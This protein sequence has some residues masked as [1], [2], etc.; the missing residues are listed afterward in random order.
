MNIFRLHIIITLLAVNFINNSLGFLEPKQKRCEIERVK[1]MLGY[2]CTNLGL[3]EIPTYL[4]SSTEVLDISQN[5]IKDLRRDS[6]D[7]LLDLKFLYLQENVIRSIQDDTFAKLTDLEALDLSGNGIMK[8]PTEIFFLPRLRNLYL[9]DNVITTFDNI[10]KT[11]IAPLQKLSLAKNKLLEIPK[12]LGILPELYHLNISSNPLSFLKPE[13]FSPFCHLR[14]VNISDSQMDSCDCENVVKY[15]TLKRQVDIFMFY[16]D[17][18]P[19]NCKRRGYEFNFTKIETSDYELC[20]SIRKQVIEHENAQLT[21]GIIGIAVF[22]FLFFFISCLYCIHRRNVRQ[23]RRKTL[24]N[25]N[26]KPKI[27]V[28]SSDAEESQ[29]S[30]DKLLINKTNV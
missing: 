11:I 7:T 24:N 26:A 14:E 1:K 21:W 20:L 22:G 8:I 29:T 12:E 18:I 17:A 4:K 2:V 27:V 13:Q 5:R 15:L 25:V 28:K 9:A 6:F 10:P 23:M 3:S 16:C 30:P 19:A